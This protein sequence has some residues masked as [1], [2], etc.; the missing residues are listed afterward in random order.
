MQVIERWFS[1]NILGMAVGRWMLLSRFLN[2]QR[3]CTTWCLVS[4]IT[5]LSCL[6]NMS[7]FLLVISTIISTWS[8]CLCLKLCDVRLQACQHLLVLCASGSGETTRRAMSNSLCWTSFL[9]PPFHLYSYE[10]NF[11]YVICCNN[12]IF[13]HESMA[14]NIDLYWGTGEFT[15]KAS[16]S[17]LNMIDDDWLMTKISFKKCYK[18]IHELRLEKSAWQAKYL[19]STCLHYAIKTFFIITYSIGLHWPARAYPGT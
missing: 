9:I 4:L 18:E 13:N 14:L 17:A 16:P 15:E 11:R 5:R 8:T 12:S 1:G 10:R 2:L 6:S 7:L 19:Q 3:D